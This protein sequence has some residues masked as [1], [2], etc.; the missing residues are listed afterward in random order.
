[1]AHGF[2]YELKYILIKWLWRDVIGK[3]R[4]LLQKTE[5][6]HILSKSK[7]TS[8]RVTFLFRDVMFVVKSKEN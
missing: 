6:N 7:K 4:H 1:M 3:S 2:K 8:I 5:K